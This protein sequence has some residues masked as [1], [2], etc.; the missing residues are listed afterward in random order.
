MTVL[1]YFNAILEYSFNSNIVK[2]A[3]CLKKKVI[4]EISLIQSVSMILQAYLSHPSL[5]IT[6]KSFAT[7][8]LVTQKFGCT[9]TEINSA[10]EI[11]LAYYKSY[12]HAI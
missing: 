9:F 6:P 5:K 11:S 4:L 1:Q 12:T 10:K 7:S 2:H 3:H 8:I